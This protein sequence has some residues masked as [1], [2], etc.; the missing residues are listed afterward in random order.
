MCFFLASVTTQV[1][2][3]RRCLF[4]TANCKKEQKGPAAPSASTIRVR[5]DWE[6][7]RVF[8]HSG[9][10]LAE[11][12]S[13]GDATPMVTGTELEAMPGVGPHIASRLRAKGIADIAALEVAAAIA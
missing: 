4:E 6:A 12:R 8:K 7:Y 3:E 5:R 13:E 9:L 11:S 2:Y 1:S 10:L